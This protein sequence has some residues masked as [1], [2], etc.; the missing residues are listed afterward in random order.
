MPRYLYLYV[1]MASI[2]YLNLVHV[3]MGFIKTC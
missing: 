2:Y 3:D 1:Y